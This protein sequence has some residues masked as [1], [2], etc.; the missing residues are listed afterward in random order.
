MPRI[1]DEAHDVREFID[2]IIKEDIPRFEN[3]FANAGTL[4]RGVRRILDIYHTLLG[5]RCEDPFFELSIV[6]EKGHVDFKSRRVLTAVPLCEVL[7]K[8]E[9]DDD[10]IARDLL[11]LFVG[12]AHLTERDDELAVQRAAVH[13]MLSHLGDDQI[14]P[15]AQIDYICPFYHCCTLD[16]RQKESHRCKEAP[17]GA[18]VWRGWRDDRT[19]WYGA[20][21]RASVGRP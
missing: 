9:G 4:G 21:S 2:G 19:C 6:N 8:N 5:R 12:G 1:W 18:A 7:Q 11:L 13:H 14:L 20:A 10:Q 3:V 17:W 15:T 16:M